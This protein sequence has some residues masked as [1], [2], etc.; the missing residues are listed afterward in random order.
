LTVGFRIQW[1]T[2]LVLMIT[3]F[4]GYLIF[5]DV[6][7]AGSYASG[8][9]IAGIAFTWGIA[10]VRA[11][12]RA[13]PALAMIVAVVTYALI[14][15]LLAVLLAAAPDIVDSAALATGLV[16]AAIS[17]VFGQFRLARPGASR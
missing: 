9:V 1:A 12:D 8:V 13:A 16:V 7:A 5:S 3:G 14:A 2:L 15:G 6:A 10:A 11:A 4:V 17:W